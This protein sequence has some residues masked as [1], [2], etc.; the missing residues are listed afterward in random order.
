MNKMNKLKKMKIK[1]QQLF[2]FTGLLFI[3]TSFTG[4]PE[5]ETTFEWSVWKTSD[6]FSGVK[7]R[8]KVLEDY[9]RN[10]DKVVVEI[11]NHYEKGI[12]FNYHITTDPSESTFYR[13][14]DV[15]S[16]D[17]RTVEKIL[18]NNKKW[19]LLVD[20]LRFEGDKYGDPYRECDRY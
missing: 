12:S 3:A 9:A 17:V 15:K 8:Y 10:K 1:I 2:L 5:A 13:L 19:Y 6:C 11:K 4:T 7:F 16:G 20:K 14:D 18:D